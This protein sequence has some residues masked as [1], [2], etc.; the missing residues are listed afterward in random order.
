MVACD[1]PTCEREWV[2]RIVVRYHSLADELDLVP[3]WLCRTQRTAF[4]EGKVV[5]SRLC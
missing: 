3:P 2:R 1:N 5:L 4:V